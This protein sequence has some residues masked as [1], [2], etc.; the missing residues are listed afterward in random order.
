MW[1]T[2]II[3]CIP[4][5]WPLFRQTFNAVASNIR[6]KRNGTSQRPSNDAAYS[7]HHSGERNVVGK[8]THGRQRDFHR[9]GSQ[10]GD[11]EEVIPLEDRTRMT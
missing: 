3:P 5:L 2:I 1:V 8:S 4:P 7:H 11:D 10:N 6:S 9:L